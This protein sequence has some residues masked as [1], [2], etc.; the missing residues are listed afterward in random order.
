MSTDRLTESD[1]QGL[2]AAEL[3]DVMQKHLDA[4]DV[5]RMDMVELFVALATYTTTQLMVGRFTAKVSGELSKRLNRDGGA[6]SDA[7]EELGTRL[8]TIPA[9]DSIT[10]VGLAQETIA[11]ETEVVA[12]RKTGYIKPATSALPGDT[13]VG[14][15]LRDL[16]CG[17]VV[18]VDEATGRPKPYDP[19]TARFKR[20]PSDVVK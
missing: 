5:E 15:A 2:E 3:E 12:D 7:S 9:G 1:R 13:P 20:T 6:P 16:V 10:V 19:T 11:A 8:P 18:V 14:T 17:A 4:V